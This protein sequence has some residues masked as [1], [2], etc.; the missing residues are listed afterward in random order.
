VRSLSG[1]RRGRNFAAPASCC[2]T[3]PTIS[4]LSVRRKRKKIARDI[5][6]DLGQS[7]A[8]MKL[9]LSLLRQEPGETVPSVRQRLEGMESLLDGTNSAP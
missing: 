4:S 8:A 6:D 9:D 1:A 3:S 2:R 7:L 5:H